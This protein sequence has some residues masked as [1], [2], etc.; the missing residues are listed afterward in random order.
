MEPPAGLGLLEGKITLAISV[1]CGFCWVDLDVLG[2]LQQLCL[3]NV[4]LFSAHVSSP[5]LK[6][7]LYS[8]RK[9]GCE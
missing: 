1:T 6:S 3:Q 4:L 8:E 9:T 5:V 2:L 7:L